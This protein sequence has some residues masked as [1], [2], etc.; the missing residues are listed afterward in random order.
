MVYLDPGSIAGYLELGDIYQKEK[1]AERAA[2][3]RTAALQL[4]KALPPGAIIENYDGITAGE[5]EGYVK[6]ML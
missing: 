4:I 6:K 2:K 3:M 5:L 1:D